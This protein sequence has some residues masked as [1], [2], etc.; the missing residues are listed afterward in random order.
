MAAIRPRVRDVLSQLRIARYQHK[1]L[2]RWQ[3]DRRREEHLE[4]LRKGIKDNPPAGW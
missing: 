4:R 2:V 1:Q 3:I